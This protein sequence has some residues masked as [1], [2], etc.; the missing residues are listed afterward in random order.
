MEPSAGRA[1]QRGFRY[2]RHGCLSDRNIERY[3]DRHLGGGGDWNPRPRDYDL[4]LAP[5][6]ATYANGRALEISDVG[7]SA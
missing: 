4:S 2:R 6:P 3:S 5:P 1:S 7:G